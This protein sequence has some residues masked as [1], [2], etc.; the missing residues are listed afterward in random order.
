M[1]TQTDNT[2][3][4]RR[5]ARRRLAAAATLLASLALAASASASGGIDPV[6][7]PSED[8]GTF[9]CV[10]RPKATLKKNGRAVAPC[11]APEEVKRAIAAA[12]SIIT[13]SYGH[14]GHG[15]WAQAR[16]SKVHDCSS[17]V[18]YALGPDGADVIPGRFT[19]WSVPLMKWGVSSKKKAPRWIE[20]FTNPSH[21]YVIIAGLRLD[22]S[23]ANATGRTRPS[24]TGPRWQKSL[25]GSPGRYKARVPTEAYL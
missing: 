10:E 13:T 11:S 19:L 4:S 22:T 12:N 14:S 20:V 24:G 15:T 23:R 21:A 5:T 2:H 18:S 25:K 16:K 3:P 17:T 6:T 9:P 8:D 7:P 1:E